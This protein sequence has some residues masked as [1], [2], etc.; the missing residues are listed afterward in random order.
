MNFT[1]FKGT[2]F[3]RSISVGLHTKRHEELNFNFFA[4]RFVAEQ[5]KVEITEVCKVAEDAFGTY[6]DPNL[7]YT[8]RVY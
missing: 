4:A 1:C 8:A 2:L 7:E 3:G 6:I 5:R